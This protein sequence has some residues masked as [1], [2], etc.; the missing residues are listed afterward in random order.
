M[1]AIFDASYVWEPLATIPWLSGERLLATIFP[2]S[3][4]LTLLGPPEESSF[5]LIVTLS[6][7]ID[8]GPM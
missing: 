7:A 2:A 1:R 5:L 4:G 8:N 3:R 6:L